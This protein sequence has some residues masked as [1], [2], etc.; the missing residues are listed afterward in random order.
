MVVVVVVVCVCGG[1]GGGGWSGLLKKV[2]IG[3]SEEDYPIIIM[4]HEKYF[5]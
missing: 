1:G 2:S 4:E 5:F 3:K